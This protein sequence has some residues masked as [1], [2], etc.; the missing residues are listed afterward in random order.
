[1]NKQRIFELA[2]RF[3]LFMSESAENMTLGRLTALD[4][5]CVDTE[6]LQGEDVPLH[7][8]NKFSFCE[9]VSNVKF[10]KDAILFLFGKELVDYEQKE[11]GIVFHLTDLGQ[12]KAC[13]FHSDFARRYRL[14]AKQ[15]LE[16]YS[17]FTEQDLLNAI[18]GV[19]KV[20]R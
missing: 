12:S 13:L 1:M 7:G 2:L 8:E 10:A 9:Y 18:L 14:L 6:K 16:Q 5:F 3:L 19:E 11:E 4:F 15:I 17:Q 20:K